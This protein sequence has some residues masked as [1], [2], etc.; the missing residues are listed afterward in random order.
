MKRSCAANVARPYLGTRANIIA[1]EP[2]ATATNTA[3][4]TFSYRDVANVS[5][6][7]PALVAPAD[8]AITYVGSCRWRVTRVPYGGTVR[9]LMRSNCAT[10]ELILEAPPNPCTDAPQNL[11]LTSAGQQT[12]T[13]EWSNMSLFFP[14]GYVFDLRGPNNQTAVRG[15][16]SADATSYTF[17][18]LTPGLTYTLYL[19]GRCFMSLYGPAA[20]APGTTLP[21]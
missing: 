6:V 2:D 18:G 12:L 1:S 21:L 14:L 5:C 19:Q 7:T 4:V 16:L 17:T 9:V 10:A 11:V 13:F 8:G 15:G 3:I 20:T